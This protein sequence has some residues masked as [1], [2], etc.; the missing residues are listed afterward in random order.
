METP[1]IEITK[2]ELARL[3]YEKGFR[4]GYDHAK[5]VALSSLSMAARRTCEVDS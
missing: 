4:D 1:K 3:Y 2:E 5:R